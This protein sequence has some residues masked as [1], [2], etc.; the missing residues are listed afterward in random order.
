MTTAFLD[1]LAFNFNVPSHLQFGQLSGIKQ[2]TG[3]ARGKNGIHLSKLNDEN[4]RILYELPR[5]S[6]APVTGLINWFDSNG[7]FLLL[8][9]TLL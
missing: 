8:S 7:K 9:T 6:V 3:T 4:Q 1:K 2:G 5:I